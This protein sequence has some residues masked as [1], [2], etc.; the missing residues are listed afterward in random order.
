M[1]Y[2]KSNYA[3]A[4]KCM[5]MN[6]SPWTGFG[7]ELAFQYQIILASDTLSILSWPVPHYCKIINVI[8]RE[9]KIKNSVKQD[10]CVNKCKKMREIG[11]LGEVGFILLC[12]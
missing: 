3:N 10:K 12:I 6:F 4:M 8:M 5:V 9:N 11:T 2:D 1:L 7:P